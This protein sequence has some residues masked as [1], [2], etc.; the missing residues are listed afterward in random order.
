MGLDLFSRKLGEGTEHL[1]ILHGLLGSADNWQTLG[2]RYA[3]E[4]TVHLVDARNHGR[5]PHSTDHSYEL[6][7][8]DLLEYLDQNEISKAH[9][10]GH[11]MGGKT[12]MTFAEKHP[13]RVAKLIVADIAPKAYTP[14]HGPIFDALLNT[15]PTSAQSRDEVQ[16]FLETKLGHEPTLVP[17]LMK[18]L[19]RV[20]EGG[21]NWRFNVET[22]AKSLGG[23][24]E[25]ITLS[26]NTIPTLFIRGRNS[27]Y[28]SDK[29]LERIE[30]LYVQLETADIED[31]GHWLHAEKPDEFFDITN[32]FLS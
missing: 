31:A 5:S 13:E 3:E 2:K 15:N 19:F 21:Y 12:V 20:K 4:F 26:L 18:G 23:V 22:L 6:M 29:E 27:N 14:H 8:E 24:T 1:I 9:L 25:E 28:V 11:S 10:L 16:N 30:D 7:C 17:F 32:E